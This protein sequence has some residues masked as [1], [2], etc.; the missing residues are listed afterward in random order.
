MI[1]LKMLAIIVA[2]AILCAIITMICYLSGWI[3]N[4]MKPDDLIESF[5]DY[6]FNG[7]VFLITVFGSLFVLYLVYLLASNI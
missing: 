7:F 1:V 4:L 5:W 2:F 6:S 3:I